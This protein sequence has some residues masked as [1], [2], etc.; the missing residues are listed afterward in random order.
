[1][2]I[3]GLTRIRNEAEIIQETLDHM[4][5]FCDEIF[6][7]D[8]C[9]TDK[10]AEICNGHDK[11]AKILMGDSWDTDRARAEW[12]N[13]NELL[14]MARCYATT[15]DW[16]VYMDADERIEFDFT[17]LASYPKD[18]TGIVM[19][20][21]DFYITPEDVDWHYSQ[22]RWIGP[23]FRPILMAFRNVGD[24]GYSKPDQREVTLPTG[25]IICSG[26]VKHYGKAISISQWNRT[27]DYYTKYFPAY[28]EKWEKR[29]GKAVHV[30]SSFGRPLITWD[31]RVDKGVLLTPKIENQ[32]IYL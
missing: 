21:F 6:V 2:K 8:D 22:R 20:L 26:Y 25:K 3:I 32:N 16:F 31:E 11:V 19:L 28:S 14:Q 12:Q 5:G 4:A 1:M 17:K 10:T 30:V 9:S 23:E 24:I 15:D 27:V 29:R 13:R 7:Y 18:V